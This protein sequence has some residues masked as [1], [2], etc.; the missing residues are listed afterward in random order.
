[1]ALLGLTFT[2]FIRREKVQEVLK[3]EQ[4]VVVVVTSSPV[5]NLNSRTPFFKAF[6][7]LLI[8]VKSLCVGTVALAGTLPV[9]S[10]DIL[11]HRFDGGGMEI[12]GPFVLVRK[13]IGTQVSVN[14]HYYIDSVSAAS[15]DVIANASEYTEERTEIS[16]GVDFLHEKTMISAGYTNSEENDFSANSVFLSIGQDF[17]GDLT[18]LTMGYARGW[19]EVGKIE[20]DFGE[21]VER[22]IYKL[23]FS[24]VLTKNSL[25]GMDIETITD[26]GY[27]NNPYRS[28]RYFDPANSSAFLTATEVYPETR[29]STA[30]AV[31][32]LYYLPYRA[33]IKGEYRYF[34]DSWGIDAH[35]YEL[36]YVH[37]FGRQWTIE[38]KVRRYSQTSA[39]F[40]SDIFSHEGAND[41]LARDKELSTLTGMTYGGGITYELGQGTIP[42]VD[43]LK[44]TLLVD[45]LKYEYDDF[46]DVTAE[47]GTLSAGTEPLYDF[48]AWVTRASITFEY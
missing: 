24:Q 10:V 48:D 3:V 11:Y 29:T 32:G 22:Q 26:E 40:Y 37:P 5:L 6:F 43:K 46:R 39:D 45:Y 19:D 31:R 9:D 21:D 2:M 42:H 13:S 28:Y 30:V 8:T 14:G 18:K 38:A 33:S 47:G 16:A 36:L 20:S 12:D 27:L 44:F 41:F 15:I 23:G 25:M 4:G 1:M 17:F 7:V 34:T 35:T